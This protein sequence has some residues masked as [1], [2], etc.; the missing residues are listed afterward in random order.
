LYELPDAFF[1]DPLPEAVDLDLN[2]AAGDSPRRFG[3]TMDKVTELYAKVIKSA[4]IR[5]D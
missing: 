1:F 3:Q 5:P 4:N 2:L